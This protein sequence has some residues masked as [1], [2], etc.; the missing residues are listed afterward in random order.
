MKTILTRSLAGICLLIAGFDQPAVAQ[1]A[2]ALNRFTL[3]GKTPLHGTVLAMCI[4]V[5][6][7]ILY[8]LIQCMRTPLARRKWWWCLFI[9]V[10][11]VQLS[12]NWTDGAWS[13]EPGRFLL[14]GAGFMKASPTSP[15]ILAVT[16]PVGALLFVFRRDALA[17]R[18]ITDPGRMD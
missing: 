8:A 7:F 15:L 13:I 4:I 10:G 16:V 3:D 18:P 6:V 17:R 2:E 12:F 5:P 1:S 9:L 14:L 11:F